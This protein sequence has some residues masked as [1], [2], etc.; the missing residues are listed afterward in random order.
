MDFLFPLLILA[1]LV[2]MFLGIRRQKKEMAKTTALQESLSVG[3]RILTTAGLHGTIVAMNDDTVD[4]EIAPGVITT[5]SRLVIREQI[6]D[7]P[8]EPAEPASD[9]APDDHENGGDT[10]P[11]LTKD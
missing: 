11:R 10:T 1:L 2:P 6:V 5:W 9:A 4:L 3:D 8:I 7:S